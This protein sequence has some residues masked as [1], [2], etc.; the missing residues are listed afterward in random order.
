MSDAEAM[1]PVIDY[2]QNPGQ[3]LRRSFE[4]G[5]FSIKNPILISG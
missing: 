2:L 4:N 1:H 5:I 3:A